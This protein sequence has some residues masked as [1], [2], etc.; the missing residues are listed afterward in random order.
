[1]NNRL[2]DF[3]SVLRIAFG[4]L[5]QR[6][7]LALEEN[8]ILFISKL[9]L[10]VSNITQPNLSTMFTDFTTIFSDR[11]RHYSFDQSAHSDLRDR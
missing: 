10:N 3:Q 9:L 8:F 7:S 11:R 4:Y 5:Q 6:S 1:M 2:F